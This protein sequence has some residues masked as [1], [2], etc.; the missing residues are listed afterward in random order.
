M[1]TVL[2]DRH[3]PPTGAEGH[4]VALVPQPGRRGVADPVGAA[5]AAEVPGDRPAV[6]EMALDLP[7][8]DVVKP[9]NAEPSWLAVID[10]AT[11]AIVH[12]AVGGTIVTLA[13]VLA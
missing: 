10:R 7:V 2:V 4:P 9:A 6:Q 3:P 1:S 8:P 13:T 11:I 12:E 5:A